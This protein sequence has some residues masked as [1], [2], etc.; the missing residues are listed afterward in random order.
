MTLII[1][2]SQLVG[3]AVVESSE[4]VKM[5]DAG[6]SIVLEVASPSYNVV[7]QGEQKEDIE[8]IELDQLKTYNDGFR[9]GF[10]E[11]FNI[12]IQH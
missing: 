9:Q 3:C 4:M 12:N 8:W 1:M 7:V 10:D 5:I 6:E 2:A 11:V